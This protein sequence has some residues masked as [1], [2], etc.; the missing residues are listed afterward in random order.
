[1]KSLEHQTENVTTTLRHKIKIILTS[2][3]LTFRSTK[4]MHLLQY[5]S[6]TINKLPTY[7]V[8]MYLLSPFQN[9]GKQRQ[10]G[11]KS[12]NTVTKQNRTLTFPHLVINS[13]NDLQKKLKRLVPH[14]LFVKTQMRCFKNCITHH[15]KHKVEI[16]SVLP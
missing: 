7:E 14:H 9:K 16:H 13:T 1:M 3:K 10:F 2:E 8:Y 5:N 12:I 11:N 6:S 4:N 15:P